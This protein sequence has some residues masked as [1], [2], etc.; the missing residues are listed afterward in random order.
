MGNAARWLMRRAALPVAASTLLTLL[1]GCDSVIY[2]YEGDCDP[3]HKVQFVYDYNLKFADAFPHEVKSVTLYLVNPQTGEIVWQ[4]H[5]S[6]PE[7]SAPGYLMDVDV[8]PGKYQMVAWGGEGHTSDFNVETFPDRGDCPPL[9][10]HLQ[11]RDD[12]TRGDDRHHVSAKLG[13]LYHG[14]V[15]LEE[16]TSNQGLHIHKVEMV[17]DTNDFHIVLQNING[18]PVDPADFSI[19]INDDNGHLDW[20]NSLLP[21]FPA[22]SYHPWFTGQV[23]AGIHVS[24][25]DLLE[26]PSNGL[27]K[28]QTQSFAALADLRTSRLVKEGKSEVT[29]HKKD[30]SLVLRLPL[31]DYCTMVKGQH[32]EMDDQEYLDRQ[33]DYS[34][35]FFLDDNNDW[36]NAYIYVNSWRIV[37]QDIDI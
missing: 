37:L 10:C 29:V 11:T 27:A 33:D 8:A 3:H 25:K 36:M 24:E 20:D 30:G 34:L 23:S 9:R 15:E 16:F 35:V 18:N 12:D 22:V 1:V 17:K 13:H 7:V 26:A 28:A 19:A 5:E 14:M 6:G 2:D 31:T 4:R 32:R 21:G